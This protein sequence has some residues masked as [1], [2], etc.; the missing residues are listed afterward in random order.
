MSSNS[1]LGGSESKPRWRSQPRHWLLAIFL[2][3]ALV[4]I[5]ISYWGMNVHGLRTQIGNRPDSEC[6]EARTCASNDLRAQVR[7]ADTTEQLLDLAMVQTVLGIASALLVGGALLL[8]IRSTEAAISAADAAQKSATLGETASK[9]QL[10]AY[11]EVELGQIVKSDPRNTVRA[12]VRLHN[13]GQTPASNVSTDFN[14]GIIPN[15]GGILDT[16][17][18]DEVARTHLV[19]GKG[20]SRLVTG[21]STFSLLEAGLND[22]KEERAVFILAGSV[23]YEDIFGETHTTEFCHI[24]YGDDLGGHYH[25]QGNA[26]T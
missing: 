25:I 9:R 5:P 17:T 15:G 11:M 7:V 12:S 20:K 19:I 10:R 18:P 6:P 23:V 3:S 1:P 8:N 24:Y 14:I 21:S 13:V 22:V 16:P 4:A 26:F 2:G